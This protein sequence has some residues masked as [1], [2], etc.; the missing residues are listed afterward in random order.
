MEAESRNLL[1]YGLLLIIG[2]AAAAGYLGLLSG[3]FMRAKLVVE[4]YREVERQVHRQEELKRTSGE[5][6]HLANYLEMQSSL[7][8]LLEE[9]GVLRRP[10]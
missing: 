2:G 4:F 7:K 8:R 10:K 6:P 9:E 1:L 3:V 5:A